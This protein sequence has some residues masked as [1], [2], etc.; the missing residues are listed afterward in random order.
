MLE[1]HGKGV[2][3]NK[4]SENIRRHQSRLE[5]VRGCWDRIAGR[6]GSEV[7]SKYGTYTDTQYNDLF[8]YL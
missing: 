7:G 6:V 1:V 8:L 5:N 4:R 3:N 2:W